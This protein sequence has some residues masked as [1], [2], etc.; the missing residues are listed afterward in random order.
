M[1]PQMEQRQIDDGRAIS[2]R[3]LAQLLPALTTAQSGL[4]V[5]ANRLAHVYVPDAAC[6]AALVAAALN[7]ARQAIALAVHTTATVDG[8][9]T[10][11]QLHPLRNGVESVAMA[12]QAWHTESGCPCGSTG[13]L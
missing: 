1:K 8:P 11:E 7:L 5:A 3:G 9:R 13:G 10:H 2:N 4:S 6:R 12:Y